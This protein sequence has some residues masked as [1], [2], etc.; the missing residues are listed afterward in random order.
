MRRLSTIFISLLLVA[1]ACGGE[2]EPAAES[3]L[4]E[5]SAEGGISLPEPLD[6]T[7][8]YLVA[9]E[10]P[11]GPETLSKLEEVDGVN[12]VVPASIRR[13]EVSG[14]EGT[15][16]LRVA[17]VDPLEY[18]SIAPLPTNEA[19]FVWTS[20]L[21]GEV[22]LTFEAA[23]KL[24]IEDGGIVELSGGREVEVGAFADNQTPNIADVVVD[25]SVEEQLPPADDQVLTVGVE[26]GTSLDALGVELTDRLPGSK[27][28]PLV[29]PSLTTNPHPRTGGG[30]DGGSGGELIGTLRYK[31]L[32]DGF[33]KPEQA[34]VDANIATTSVSIIGEVSCHRLMLPQLQAALAEIASEGF[35]G[36]LRPGDYGGCYVPRFI[37]RNPEL[38]LS[39]HAFGLA[40]DLNV[41]TNHLGTA[42]DMD[43]RVVEIF[44]R[45]GFVWG[46]DWSRPDP[47]H[48]EL[49]RLVETG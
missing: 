9:P 22:V 17:A 39:M 27:L 19:E 18:R 2:A 6:A 43:P 1:A 36:R 21:G 35:A 41:S 49:G 31:V 23:E 44:E 42:G 34:W 15:R 30:E 16:E 5:A 7:A 8:A 29:P 46:G 11:A 24:G 26:P 33:I 28:V 45:W 47:M 13:M 48:F 38:P 4:T 20:L 12:L 37:D 25:L 3:L 10:S 14:P 40:I 32:D